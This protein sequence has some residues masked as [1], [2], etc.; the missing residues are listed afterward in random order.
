MKLDIQ[1]KDISR[2]SA[3]HHPHHGIG[4]VQSV[5]TRNFAGANDLPYA[6]LY[7]KRED[8]TLIVPADALADS[9]RAPLDAD[10]AQQVLDH[11]KE[12]NGKPRRQWKARAA[13][14]QEAID[15]GDPFEYAEIFKALTQL[16]AEGS[17]RHT[18][19]RHLNRSMEFLVDELAFALNKSDDQARRLITRAAEEAA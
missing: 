19:R 9:V 14:H 16:E 12:W 1:T 7:F 17:L 2:G 3:V 6:Q 18:D 13:A 15:R 5:R 4:R 11:L 8:L 10:Q